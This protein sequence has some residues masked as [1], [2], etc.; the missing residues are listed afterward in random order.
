MFEIGLIANLPAGFRTN[1]NQRQTSSTTTKMKYLL[2]QAKLLDGFNL[3][4]KI[5]I[6]GW[7]SKLLFLLFIGLVVFWLTSRVTLL[8]PSATEPTVIMESR[9]GFDPPIPF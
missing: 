4:T 3:D 5:R 7:I 8:M 1:L 6:V 9:A 2:Y